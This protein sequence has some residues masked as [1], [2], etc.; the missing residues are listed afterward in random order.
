MHTSIPISSLRRSP[1]AFIAFAHGVLALLWTGIAPALY[2]QEQTTETADN[3]III[4]RDLPEL[5]PIQNGFLG[6]TTEGGI[7]RL[8]LFDTLLTNRSQTPYRDL[9]PKDIALTGSPLPSGVLLLAAP[10]GRA[11]LFAIRTH[12]APELTPLWSTHIVRP[13]K[14]LATGDFSGDGSGEIAILADSALVVISPDGR[15]RYAYEGDLLDAVFYRQGRTAQFIIAERTRSQI[16]LICLDAETGIIAD[17]RSIPGESAILMQMAQYPRGTMVGIVTLGQK[18][19][20]YLFDPHQKTFARQLIMPTSP[21]ALVP[22]S[23]DDGP[24]LAV[25]FRKYPSP[26]LL[27]LREHAEE[28]ELDF[29]LYNVFENVASSS[30]Y[31]VL[32]GTDSV[33]VYDRSME[34]LAV[35]SGTGSSNVR[36]HELDS[37]TV[38]L[39]SPSGSIIEHIEPDSF[40]WLKRNWPV[41]V[42]GLFGI[43]LLGIIYSAI[44]RY[45]FIRAIYSNLVHV[46]ESNGIV[47]ISRSQK[48]QHL[49]ASA[50]T[51]LEIDPYIQI[52]RH[53]SNYL[54]HED[55]QPVPPVLRNLFSE[56]ELFQ[57]KTDVLLSGEKRALRFRGRPMYGNYGQAVGYLLL[58]DDIT[59]TLEHER[60]VN[61]A[62]VAHHIA[63]EM[64][65]P[66]GTVKTTAETLLDRLH[67]NDQNSADLRAV[68]RIIRQSGRLREIVE[69]LLSVARTEAM[70]KIQADLSLMLSSLVHDFMEYL[71]SNVELEY[72][73][74]GEDFRCQI[75]V[76]QL[77]VAIRNLLDN[78]R[79]AIGSR[80][81]GRITLRVESRE[82]HLLVTVQDNGI[83]MNE[84]T[85]ARLFQPYYT[86][87][88]GGSGIGTVIIKR[89]I[90]GH[91]GTIAVE[92]AP[93]IGTTF[94][95]KIPRQ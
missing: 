46:P 74:K 44:R 92:S 68:N 72:K 37:V 55:L 10:F 28:D 30:R 27:P 67:A 18:S 16:N 79:Q 21:Y 34:L 50:R 23:D 38:L 1:C 76:N 41:L 12:G 20:A 5:Y 93:G 81:G 42:V 36:L 87:R 8:T 47:V 49:N 35:L 57:L 80:Q 71:P 90:E 2:A 40:L 39:S 32:A 75:D 64:K 9:N 7:T 51:F 4:R 63:H 59:E 54:V 53:I 52:G 3:A 70:Q 62:S 45:R 66:L 13:R 33:A 11:S 43:I 88:E 61:W 19:K 31:T 78:A 95:I 69:D 22:Y 73:P 85:L 84:K 17:Q 58:I 83:G 6:V 60:L 48:V 25:L 94:H 77:T 24:A 29:P 91:G 15:E 56:G 82:E 65:T 14:I 86:E 89:V 26:T